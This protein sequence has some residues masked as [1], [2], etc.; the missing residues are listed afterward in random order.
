MDLQ[1]QQAHMLP[2]G[3]QG[4]HGCHVRPRMLSL[5]PLHSILLPLHVRA[6]GRQSL[7][8]GEIKVRHF[9]S[10]TVAEL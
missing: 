9:D 4:E 2:D 1:Q 8:G 7:Q 6:E 5:L 3:V 10:K